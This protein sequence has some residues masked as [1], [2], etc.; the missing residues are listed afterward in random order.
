LRIYEKLQRDKE[1]RAEAEEWIITAK[2]NSSKQS[3]SR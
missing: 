2:L 1:Y 3:E